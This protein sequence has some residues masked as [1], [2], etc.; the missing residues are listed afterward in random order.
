M[1]L[2]QVTQSSDFAPS[3]HGMRRLGNLTRCMKDSSDDVVSHDWAFDLHM[4]L[5]PDSIAS[6]VVSA[7]RTISLFILLS[8]SVWLVEAV[9]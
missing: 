3:R 7:V 1:P 4:I 8:M 2:L 9:G 5:Q 6:K